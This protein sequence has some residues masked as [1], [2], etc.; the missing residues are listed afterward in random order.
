MTRSMFEESQ[1]EFGTPIVVRDYR[2]EVFRKPPGEIRMVGEVHDTKPDG[3]TPDDPD[4]LD[5][6]R[7]TLIVDV[8]IPDLTITS[9]RAEMQT[10]PNEECPTIVEAYEQVVGLSIARGFTHAVRE[11]LGGPRACTHLTMLLQ[12]MAPVAWQGL[13][14]YPEDFAFP[15]IGSDE[16]RR[17]MEMGVQINRNTCHMFTEGG[18]MDQR[19]AAGT[20]TIPLWA[21]KRRSELDARKT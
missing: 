9:C 20:A 21:R 17:W 8:H 13:F 3:L 1:A 15:E 11:R 6:H 2:V 5:V 4:P 19:V 14:G 7:M 16:E 18:I 12:A 10:H